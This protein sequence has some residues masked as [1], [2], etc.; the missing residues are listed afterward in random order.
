MSLGLEA[1]LID[2]LRAGRIDSRKGGRERERGTKFPPSDASRP[3]KKWR[4]GSLSLFLAALDLLIR[5]KE[6]RTRGERTPTPT[7]GLTT[8]TFTRAPYKDAPFEYHPNTPQVFPYP[9]LDPKRLGNDT[10]NVKE[11]TFQSL[12]TS[13]LFF[14]SSSSSSSMG[15][16]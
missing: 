6:E 12:D 8:T 10:Q 16:L 5:V 13:L 3:H 11:K 15:S 4:R 14:L 9:R 7:W 2:S 1:S